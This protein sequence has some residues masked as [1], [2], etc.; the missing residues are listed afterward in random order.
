MNFITQNKKA[1]Q[2]CEASK[3][4]G[5]VESASGGQLVVVQS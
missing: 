3:A 1:P 2:N 5:G 4:V